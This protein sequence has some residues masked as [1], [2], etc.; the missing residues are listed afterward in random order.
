MADEMPVGGVKPD[1]ALKATVLRPLPGRSFRQYSYPRLK[2]GGYLFTVRALVAATMV[3]SGGSSDCKRR[4]FSTICSIAITLTAFR[5]PDKSASQVR[6]FGSRPGNVA[7]VGCFHDNVAY[8]FFQLLLGHQS[9][10][11][12]RLE[13]VGN[14]EAFAAIHAG[15]ILFYPVLDRRHKEIG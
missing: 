15:H 11:Y 13:F 9:C 5:S 14:L 4:T 8:H 3:T 6:R 10:R 7:P 12:L 2:C 1:F